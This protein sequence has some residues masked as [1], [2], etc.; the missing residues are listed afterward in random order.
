RRFMTLYTMAAKNH[1]ILTILL[2]LF[3]GI[4]TYSVTH[5]LQPNKNTDFPSSSNDFNPHMNLVRETRYKLIAPLLL[6]DIDLPNQNYAPIL[7]KGKSDIDSAK[8]A[9]YLTESAIY[10]RNLNDGSWIGHNEHMAF[11]PGSIL[12]LSILIG[13]MRWSEAQ[14]GILNSLVKFD[15]PIPNLPFQNI[16]GKS[17]Q[18]GKTYSVRELIEFMILES[19]NQAN[20]I[21][22]SQLPTQYGLSVFSDLGIRTPD[23]NAKAFPMSAAEL[24]RFLR[25]LY[26]STYLNERDS[27]W[28]LNLLTK[29]RF[30]SGIRSGV[31]QD[32]T[33][34]HKFGERGYQDSAIVEVHE[35]A[36]IYQNGNPYL[37]TIMTKGTSRESQID[38]IRRI[39]S[40]TFNLVTAANP[41]TI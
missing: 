21:L 10:F 3:T 25:S 24:S 13:Y 28:A 41:A 32:V 38:L 31:P 15:K 12:K 20:A 11:D 1:W 29:S 40:H 37:I 30:G 35:T 19:D 9:G 16:Q 5:C 36:I 26:N 17:L 14:P 27:E 22:N 8:A 7:E 33:V 39:S 18:L 23:K 4:M 2:C 6:A 34:A